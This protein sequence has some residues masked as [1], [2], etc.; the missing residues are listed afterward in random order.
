MGRPR[1]TPP[2]PAAE[3]GAGAAALGGG[4]GAVY[5]GRGPVCGM[6]TRRAGAVSDAISGASASG[7]ET[8]GSAGATGAGGNTGTPGVVTDGIIGAIDICC[9]GGGA[10][11]A[12]AATGAPGPLAA[13]AGRGWLAGCA[14]PWPAVARGGRATIGPAGG[15]AAMAGA[16]MICGAWRGRGTIRR[17]AGREGSA[18][19]PAPGIPGRTDVPGRTIPCCAGGGGAELGIPVAATDEAG[20][21]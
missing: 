10:A 8:D 17:G 4:A 18:P 20:C 2:G 21:G 9:E 5:T 6:M 11:A 16:A 7:I 3:D 1:W 13:L 14:V 15:L 12:R 19:G